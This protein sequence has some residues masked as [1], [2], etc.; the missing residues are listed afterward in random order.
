[1]AEETLNQDS[2]LTREEWLAKFQNNDGEF[3]FCESCGETPCAFANCGLEVIQLG[4][5]R[6]EYGV[7]SNDIIR[8]ACYKAFVYLKYGHL[9]MGR[10]IEIPRCILEE[11]R[12]YWPNE[13]G[14]SYM[15]HR[16]S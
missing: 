10:R 12:K 14:S 3:L 2:Q 16:E 11:I 9:G 4:H 8:K 13:V 7:T 5:S 1:M 15:G 6:Y